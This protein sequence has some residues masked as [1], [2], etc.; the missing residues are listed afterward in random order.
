MTQQVQ[1]DG[2]LFLQVWEYFAEK[3]HRTLEESKIFLELDEKVDRLI[4]R[5]LFSK[6][7]RAATQEEKDAARLEYLQHKAGYRNS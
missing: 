1:I 5:S 2:D 6:Y 3:E 4:A 7:K